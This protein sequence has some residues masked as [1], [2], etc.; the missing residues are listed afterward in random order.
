MD[1]VPLFRVFMV[2]KHSKKPCPNILPQLCVTIIN[3]P[4]AHFPSVERRIRWYLPNSYRGQ[5]PLNYQSTKMTMQRSITASNIQL[6]TQS[7]TT[8]PNFH[9][10]KSSATLSPTSNTKQGELNCNLRLIQLPINDV[11]S[12]VTRSDSSITS[13]C[14][15]LASTSFR[16]YTIRRTRQARVQKQILDFHRWPYRTF[17][18]YTLT[19][20]HTR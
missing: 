6:L 1:N 11:V 3:E 20:V 4:E 17:V 13:V 9:C 10:T 2:S 18:E 16:R 8:P 7:Q 14:K 5:S 12:N 19:K 15:G